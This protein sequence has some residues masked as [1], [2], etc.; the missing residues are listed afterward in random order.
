MHNCG[1]SCGLHLLLSDNYPNL[2]SFNQLKSIQQ[3]PLSVQTIVPLITQ[4]A[5][6][7]LEKVRAIW[8]WL[9]HN[10]SKYVFITGLFGVVGGISISPETWGAMLMLGKEVGVLAS[11]GIGIRLFCDG[12][13]QHLHI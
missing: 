4:V 3:S 11:S 13:F 1:E 12:K 9:C 6:S 8:V 2:V 5:R 10:I 7:Q